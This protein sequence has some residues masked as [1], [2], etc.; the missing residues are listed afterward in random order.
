MVDNINLLKEKVNE[1]KKRINRLLDGESGAFCCLYGRRRCGKTRLLRECL[2]GRSNVLYYVAD[3]SDRAAQLS[4]FINEAAA[5]NPVI[6]SAAGLD[7]SSVLDLW[8]AMI[9]LAI[10]VILLSDP[11]ISSTSIPSTKALSFSS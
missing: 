4:R 9:W 1:E 3:K 10:M 8:L 2:R 5:L 7:W 6:A 11:I